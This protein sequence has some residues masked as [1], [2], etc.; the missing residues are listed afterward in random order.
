MKLSSRFPNAKYD[1]IGDYFGDYLGEFERAAT[2][3]SRHTLEKAR[4]LMAECLR[5]D[6]TIFSCGNGGSAAIANHLVCD[7]GKGVRSDTGI[8]PRV[9]SL[10]SNPE[11]LTAIGNDLD[12]AETFSA[13]LDGF[14]RRGDLLISV[15]SS[16]NSE[17]I[18]RAVQWARDNGVAT[19]A[20]TGFSGGRSAQIADVN[21]H[22]ASD[23]YGVVEDLHQSLTHVL[24]QFTRQ[25]LM[26]AD[27]VAQ[28]KF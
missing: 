11:I 6:G 17:N 26:S 12:Y 9:R 24:A 23:N 8:R 19:I 3:V 22:V 13:Q 20:L 28:R 18:V 25:S 27:L 4:Q 2:T 15:S 5:N 21:L 1:D 7:L 14:A 16:G 10:S